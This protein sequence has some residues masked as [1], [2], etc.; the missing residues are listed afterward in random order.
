MDQ[1]LTE[2]TQAGATVPEIREALGMGGYESLR[3][4]HRQVHLGLREP[5]AKRGPKAAPDEASEEIPEGELA[6]C[7]MQALKGIASGEL[8]AEHG[9]AFADM[10]RALHE[11]QML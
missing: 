7:C 3:V 10:I 8:S 9:A 6:A 11:V 1:K 2:M 4:T 5:R